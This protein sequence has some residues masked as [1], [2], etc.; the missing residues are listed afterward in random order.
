MGEYRYRVV[1]QELDELLT[2]LAAVA[3]EGPKA[4]GK[5]ATA[6]RRADVV[7]ALD[8]PAQRELLAADPARLDRASG[9]VLVDEWQRLPE[10]WD[11][12]RRSV[13]RDQRAGHFLLTGSGAPRD[14][15][16]HSG[17]GRIVQVRMRPMGLTERGLDTPSVSL[18]ELLTGQRPEIDGKATLNLADYTDEVVRSG[19][20]GIRGLPPRARRAQLDGYLTRVVERE[21]PE[22]GMVVRRPATLRAWLAGYAAATSSTASY[23]AILEAA[24]PGQANKPAKTTVIGYRDVLDSLWL[25]DP[26][27]GWLPS[28]NHFTRLAQAPKHHLA[29][30]ALAARLLGVDAE[31]LL[32]GRT[33]PVLRDGAFLGRLFESLVTLTVRVLAQA[34]EASV[35]HLRTRNGDHEVDL[36]VQRPDRGVVAIEVKL[37]PVVA[38]A[39]VVHLHWLREK[40]GSGLLDAAVITTGP[41]AYRRADGIAVIPAS[42]LGP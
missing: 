9:L 39:D 16:S 5:T 18:R 10:V 11:L 4:V 40:L 37:A 36:I 3:I 22:Q 34:A 42:L 38:D 21:F 35:H 30:P 14:A 24:T 2:G 1:D 26:V 33:P 7:F 12:V 8:E 17:A 25:L 23:N 19:F 41:H 32:S 13:D 28:G 29:D 15:P 20:P 6:Q 31:A 27:P